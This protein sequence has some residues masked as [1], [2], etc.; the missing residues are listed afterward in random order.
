V[1]VLTDPLGWFTL[2]I[3][4]GWDCETE[5]CVTTLRSPQGIGVVY[6]SGGRH[7]GGRQAEFGGGE[8]LAR[9]LRFLGV[10]VDAT[11]LGS[12]QGAGCRIYFYERRNDGVLWRYWSV[13][14]DETA[15][16]IAY[17]CDASRIGGEAE[18]VEDIVRTVRLYHSA[19]AN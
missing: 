7:V 1:P 6:L 17:N 18:V 15:L 14:D 3:P 4:D 10:S 9:F 5:D 19:P 2:E 12:S 13:T 16:L 8:F 11:S